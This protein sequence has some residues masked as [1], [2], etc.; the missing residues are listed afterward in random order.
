MMSGSRPVTASSRVHRTRRRK[1][2]DALT[3]GLLR[4]HAQLLETIPWENASGLERCT[5]GERGLQCREPAFP[6]EEYC[7]RHSDDAWKQ[8]TF[9]SKKQVQRKVMTVA[10]RRK[11]GVRTVEDLERLRSQS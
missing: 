3:L 8:R 2:P 4:L 7:W 5:H 1:R 9:T 6:G 11:L 10:A